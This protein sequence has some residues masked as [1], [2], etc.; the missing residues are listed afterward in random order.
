MCVNYLM[1]TVLFFSCFLIV[2]SKQFFQVSSAL[3][4]EIRRLAILVDEF[5][6]P[7]ETSALVLNLYKK[8]SLFLHYYYFCCHSFN[9]L[10]HF[11]K[12]NTCDQEV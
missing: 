10:V 11:I 7:F 12:I 4:D 1:I 5:N 9:F 8:V 3:T 6:H 2:Y